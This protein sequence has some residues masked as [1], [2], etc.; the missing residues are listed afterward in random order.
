METVKFQIHRVNEG[1]YAR[2]GASGTR[3]LQKIYLLCRS[4]VCSLP[5]AISNRTEIS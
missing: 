4:S 1:A 3:A 5:H 2:C